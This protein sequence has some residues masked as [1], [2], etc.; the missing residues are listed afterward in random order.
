M[1]ISDKMNYTQVN[2]SIQK[3]RGDM[4]HIQNQAATLKRINRPSDDPVATARLLAARTDN[5]VHLQFEKNTQAAQ[6]F[7][8]FTD[9]ALEDLTNI[10]MRAKE[11]A[12]GQA[13]SASSNATSR[14]VVAAEVEQLLD[15]AVSISNSKMGD[16]FVFGGFSTTTKPFDA[17]LNYRGD[18]GNMMVEIG[19]SSYIAMNIPGSKAFLGIEL[20][21]E[22]YDKDAIAKE[23]LSYNRVKPDESPRVSTPEQSNI[24]SQESIDQSIQQSSQNQIR[25]PASGPNLT[26]KEQEAL[27][28]EQKGIN[29]FHVLKQLKIALETDSSLGIQNGLDEID[30]SIDQIVASRAKV[31]SRM[32]V[33]DSNIQALE[34]AK[35]DSKILISQFEDADAFETYSE[36]KKV[37]GN[38]QATLQTSGKLIQPSLLDFLR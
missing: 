17:D 14:A 28:A 9:R 6:N 23:D 11:L 29:I 24:P 7:L 33:L 16:R 36:L 35:V 26:E 1:R 15:Q 3:N 31:G 4:S 38:L 21:A 20:T 19:K 32:G 2:D 27:S 34:K 22:P 5:E 10:Y 37:E 8:R 13:N 12:L 25:G 18:H 30:K